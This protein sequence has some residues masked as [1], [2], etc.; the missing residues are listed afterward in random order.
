MLRAEH[1]AKVQ[2]G[3]CLG[4]QPT[5]VPIPTF[6]GHG[7]VQGPVAIMLGKLGNSQACR[8]VQVDLAPPREVRPSF[9]EKY[10]HWGRR[11]GRWVGCWHIRI[12]DVCR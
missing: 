1:D 5:A 11:G 10:P 9:M 2:L 3:R 7:W 4:S 8:G 12:L 6:L